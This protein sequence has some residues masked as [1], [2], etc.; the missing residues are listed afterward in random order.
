[1]APKAFFY[2]DNE[3]GNSETQSY[4]IIEDFGLNGEDVIEL[5]GSSEDY[6]LAETSDNL[7]QGVGIFLDT[8]I[9]S[10]SELIGI[11]QNTGLASVAL[12]NSNQFTFI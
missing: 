9:E 10:Q 12:D 3:A 6:F 8:E 2:V 11:L 5:A 1:M 4:G 7:P